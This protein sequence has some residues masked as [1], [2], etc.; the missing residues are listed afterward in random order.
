MVNRSLFLI[1]LGIGLL[2]LIAYYFSNILLYFAI[3]LVL[4]TI[5]R[6]L[7]NYINSTHIYSVQIP[8]AVAAIISFLVLVLVIAVFVTLFIPLVS[9]QIQ[10][11]TN[12]NY[13]ALFQRLTTPVRSIENFLIRNNLSVKEEGYLANTIKHNITS[14]IERVNFNQ[15]FNELISFTGSIF[16]GFLAIVF[17]TF[18]L[19]LEKGL[20]RKQFISMIPNQYFELAITALYKIEKLLSNYLLGLL[21]Q[22]F[23]IFSIASLGLSLI[24]VKYSLTIALFAAFANL[25][26]YAGPIL[27][28]VFGIIVGI[29]TGANLHDMNDY[30]ILVLKIGIVFGVV[31]VTDNILL[32]PI[33]FSKSVKA[34]PLEIFVVIFAGANIAGVIGMIAA[35]PVYTIFRVSIIELLE[36]YKK[37]YIFKSKN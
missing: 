5:L 8:R 31:Q 22:M 36:G 18:A 35:I 2:I 9:E 4:A 23:A 20:I 3:S 27:G 10:V 21:F 29:S 17:I 11:L 7:T 16:V 33:I 24:G 37:Y 25:I 28:A 19:L 13:E 12:I 15:I 34:H 32:Q 6:P 1:A 30:L 26:P 14:I